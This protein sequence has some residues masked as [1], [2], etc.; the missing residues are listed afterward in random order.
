[1]ARKLASETILMPGVIRESLQSLLRVLYMFD[2]VSFSDV[3]TML[4]HGT[5]LMVPTSFGCS[6]YSPLESF[7]NY[8]IALLIDY[9]GV[10]QL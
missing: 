5:I 7:G 4:L 2:S 8:L 10:F 3:L 1:M 9:Y 6:K